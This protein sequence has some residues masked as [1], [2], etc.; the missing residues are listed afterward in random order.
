V[1]GRRA[2]A[3]GLGIDTEPAIPGHGAGNPEKAEADAK[4]REIVAALMLEAEPL[5]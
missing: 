5:I 4:R 1:V 3:N 2:A